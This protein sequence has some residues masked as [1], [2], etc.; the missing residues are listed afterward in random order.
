MV[1]KKNVCRDSRTLQCKCYGSDAQLD[2]LLELLSE[3]FET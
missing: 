3:D 1:F 2:D